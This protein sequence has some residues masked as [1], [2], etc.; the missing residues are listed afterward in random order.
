M[1]YKVYEDENRIIKC[2]NKDCLGW[3]SVISYSFSD[4]KC[5]RIANAKM[6]PLTGKIRYFCPCCGTNLG[7]KP[8]SS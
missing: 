6:I 4:T 7:A 2:T 1:S 5:T 8:K 3:F